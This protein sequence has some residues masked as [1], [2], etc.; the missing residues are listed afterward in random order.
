M[1]E[2]TVNEDHLVAARKDDVGIAG[3]VAAMKTKTKAECMQK[4]SYHEFRLCI[5]FSDPRHAFRT[6]QLYAINS[7]F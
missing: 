7:S 2:A 1:P 5:D 3:K 4:L 6:A